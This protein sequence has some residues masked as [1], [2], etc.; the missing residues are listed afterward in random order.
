MEKAKK[1]TSIESVRHSLAHLLAMAVLKKFPRAKLGIGPTIENGFYYDF[2]LPKPI[3]EGDLRELEGT[4]RGLIAQRLSFTGKRVTSVEARKIFRNQPFKLDLIKEFTKAKRQ[5]TVYETAPPAERGASGKSSSRAQAQAAGKPKAFIDLCRGGH[6]KDTSEIP[7]DAFRLTKIAGAYWRGDEKNPQLTRIYGAAFATKN[8]LDRHLWQEEEVKRRDH[9]VLGVKLGLFSQHDI[10]PG[11]VFWH[12]KGMILWR[13]LEKFMRGKLD[14]AGYEEVSTPIMVKKKVFETSG[15]WAYYRESMFAV[16]LGEETYVLKPMNCPEST[17]IYAA[18]LRS[19]R[20][21]PLRYSEITDRLHRNELAG[22]L[23]GL[24][25]VRQ[26][27]Q[28]DAHI[29]CRPDQI[30]SEVR[31]LINL[32]KDVYGTFNLPVNLKLATKPGKAM[33]A[34]KLWKEAEEALAAVLRTSGIRYEVKPKDGAFY[35]PK[36]DAHVEDVLKRDW[37]IATIQL[38]FQMPRRFHLSYIDAAGKKQ[39]PVMIHRAVLGTFER[40]IGLLIEHYAGAFPLWLAPVQVGVLS[41]TDTARSYCREVARTLVENGIR[42]TIDDRNE[43]IGKKIREAE[44]Q[45]IP[46]LLIV[47]PREAQS[48]TVSVRERGKGDRGKMTLEKFLAKIA[49]EVKP[50]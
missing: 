11:A 24:F 23:G 9:R 14:R 39:T 16:P 43:T 17:Y 13:E 25:R 34:P 7:A 12:G 30:E 40:F 21:L 31:N 19:Y 5:L 33:G 22:V 46:Y 41:V 10:A 8:E 2:K 50:L 15:H 6:V 49:L 38:D 42:I 48:K 3:A 18:R 20:D 37:Q 36:I 45:K 32:V 47:G 26:M 27:T 4:M 35:G 1:Q 28:D 44:L 29:Y